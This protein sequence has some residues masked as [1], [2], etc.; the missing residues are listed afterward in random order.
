MASSTLTTLLVPFD[1]A[2]YSF[3]VSKLPLPVPCQSS[4]HCP[5][6]EIA[7]I[8]SLRAKSMTLNIPASKVKSFESFIKYY[9]TRRS[10]T[11]AMM[12]WLVTLNPESEG[13]QVD[14]PVVWFERS[15]VFPWVLWGELGA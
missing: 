3:I 10:L 11:A 14:F 7:M 8:T 9:Y 1:L 2:L 15:V 5:G 13:H 4:C 12:P 6:P